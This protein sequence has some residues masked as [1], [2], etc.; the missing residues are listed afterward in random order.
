MKK[1]TGVR[2]GVSIVV[3]SA[4][5]AEDAV[6]PKG[7]TVT[8]Q[9][10]SGAGLASKFP[11]D[12][13]IGKHPAVIFADDFEMGAVGVSRQVLARHLHLRQAIPPLAVTPFDCELDRRFPGVGVQEGEDEM[14]PAR[15]EVRCRLE[16]EGQLVFAGQPGTDVGVRGES[17]GTLFAASLSQRP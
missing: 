7:E 13:K 1:W 5:A 11:G 3:W 17:G 2:M 12:R 16:V 10:K 4:C 9:L 14:V 15:C 6:S 8:D